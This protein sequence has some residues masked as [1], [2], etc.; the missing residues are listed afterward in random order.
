MANVYRL[1]SSKQYLNLDFVSL[2]TEQED[3]SVVV[4]AIV[5]Q[6]NEQVIEGDDAKYRLNRVAEEVRRL[7]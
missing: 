1:S 2:I 4:V 5:D 6:A 7:K 3:G